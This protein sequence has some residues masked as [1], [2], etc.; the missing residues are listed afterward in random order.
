[1][2]E[3]EKL[4]NDIDTLLVYM[5]DDL[6]KE[7]F[8]IEDAFFN[9]LPKQNENSQVLSINSWTQ[10]YLEKLIKTCNTRSLIKHKRSAHRDLIGAV[11]L[12][13][14]GQS[15]ALSVKHGRNRSYELGS[16]MQIATLTVHGA[17]Q[18]GNGNIQ[19]F[20]D[21]FQPLRSQIE[22][23]EVSDE[24]KAEVINIIDML[25]GHSLIRSL[26]SNL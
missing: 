6:E 24:E 8:L 18:I 26:S 17:A 1:M 12:T 25:E 5:S 21:F 10:E 15:R 14:E 22:L 16:G 20:K 19:N 9:F 13:E 11:A 23:M 3:A 4:Q 2:S 7:G